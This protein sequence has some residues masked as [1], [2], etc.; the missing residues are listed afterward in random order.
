MAKHQSPLLHKDF[1]AATRAS[2]F[3]DSP[4]GRLF[5]ICIFSV[6]FKGGIKSHTKLKWMSE[7]GNLMMEL[8]LLDLFPYRKW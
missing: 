4:S 5:V 2:I 6:K 3:K 1:I 7:Q 8:H